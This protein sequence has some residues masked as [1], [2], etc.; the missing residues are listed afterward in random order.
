[1]AS[2]VLAVGYPSLSGGI[3]NNELTFYGDFCIVTPVFWQKES[4]WHRFLKM[5]VQALQLSVSIV[6]AVAK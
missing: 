4:L 6:L 2:I 3:F 5:L 1:A